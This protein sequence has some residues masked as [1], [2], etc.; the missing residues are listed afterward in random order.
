MRIVVLLLALVGAAGSGFVGLSALE[1]IEKGQKE[2]DAAKA[3]GRPVAGE[4][5]WN[6]LKIAVYALIAGIPI[7]VIGG[8]LALNRKGKLAAVLLLASYAVPIVFL[9]VSV[10]LDFSD[11]VVKIIVLF[12]AGLAVAGLLAFFVS[13][14]IP[15]Q[16]PKK[17]RVGIS[18]DDDLVG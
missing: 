1:G 17:K 16:P 12:P 10:G 8:F 13:P 5:R 11:D 15:F 14:G 2:I 6:N 9:A 18:E 7:G 3:Q 4:A